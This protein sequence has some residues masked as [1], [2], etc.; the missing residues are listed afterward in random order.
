MLVGSGVSR[1]AG[2]LTGWEITLDLIHRL[3]ELRGAD[4]GGEPEQWFRSTFD[5]EPGYSSILERLAPSA[6]ER[7]LLLAGYFEPTADERVQG[8]KVPTAAHRGI[9]QV[10]AGGY[11]RVIVTTNFDR[12]IEDS[13]G[14]AGVVPRVIASADHA[15][16]ATPLV[17][18]D[19][20]V[21]K[22]HGDYLSPD[23]KNTEAELSRYE[24]AMRRLL[25]EVFDQYGLVVCGWSA[26]WDVALRRAFLR[27]PSRRFSTYWMHRP[28][29]SS[30]AEDLIAHRQAIKVP[31]A[32]ADSAFDQL[33]QNI[34]ALETIADRA[35]NDTAV[36]VARLKRY[37]PDPMRRIDLHDLISDETERTIDEVSSLTPEGDSAEERYVAHLQGYEGSCARLVSLLA[38]GAYFSDRDDHDEL[39]TR[40]VQSLATRTAPT[41][42]VSS[43]V[44]E[45]LKQYPGLLA[46]YAVSIGAIGARR[47]QPLVGIL[48]SIKVSLMNSSF[49]I[50]V[51]ASLPFVFPNAGMTRSAMP[52][53]ARQTVPESEHLFVLLQPAVAEIIPDERRYEAVFDET[54]YLLGLVYAAQTDWDGPPIGRI[55]NRR[56]LSSDLP[57]AAVDRHADLLIEAGIFKSH[58]HLKNLRQ[59][60]DNDIRQFSPHPFLSPR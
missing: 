21:I 42:Q 13:I 9:A 40:C 20:T 23:L 52:T 39:W 30:T 1:G 19:C 35:P 37:L 44:F 49:P 36:A 18:S 59:S 15:R 43:Q 56:L 41:P 27:S 54:E 17:H 34:A 6:D 46:L 10:V 48:G 26:E 14:N 7:Q 50:A 45:R 51:A 53:L 31:I 28:T 24:T 58:D 47:V 5:A 8:L 38:T 4:V 16:G 60:Y 22:V 2:I 3:A 12:L 32:D 57:T 25:R 11:V 55:A 29:L 33:A